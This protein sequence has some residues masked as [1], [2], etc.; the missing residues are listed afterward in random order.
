MQTFLVD[1]L[2]P[3]IE[4]KANAA[5]VLRESL[6]FAGQSFVLW[7]EAPRAGADSSAAHLFQKN[8]LRMIS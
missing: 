2:L 5:F 6:S 7:N 3:K 8:L 1:A 4:A